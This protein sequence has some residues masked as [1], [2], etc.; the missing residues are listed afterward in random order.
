MITR[1]AEQFRV[2]ALLRRIEQHS[3]L[4]LT[5]VSTPFLGEETPSPNPKSAQ[6]ANGSSLAFCG[7][8]ACVCNI[9]R[10]M[11]GLGV[12]FLFCFTKILL[13]YMYFILQVVFFSL[14]I[15]LSH[16]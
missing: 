4:I 1:Q 9:Y 16:F 12:L 5:S 2:G 10:R 11:K 15:L 14:N 3:L 13:Y 6:A 7:F 8:S